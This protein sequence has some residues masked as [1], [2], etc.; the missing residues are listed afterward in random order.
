MTLAEIVFQQKKLEQK[1]GVEGKVAGRYVEAGFHV[2]MH[3]NTKHGRV[4]FV[5]IKGGE[6]FAVD[7]I[8]GKKVV[9]KEELEAIKKKAESLGAKPILVLYGSGVVLGDDA[10]EFIKEGSVTVKRIRG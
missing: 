3:V 9:K 2:R 8:S 10:K 4:S 6:K 1:Y 5:A 7:V